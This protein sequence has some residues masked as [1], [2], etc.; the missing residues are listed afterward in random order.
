MNEKRRTKAQHHRSNNNRPPARQASNR[1]AGNR[2]PNEADS[3]Q[4]ASTEQTGPTTCAA[5][6]S[7]LVQNLW[8]GLAHD[9]D[10]AGA[11]AAAVQA[12]SSHKHTGQVVA[13]H[14]DRWL[15]ATKAPYWCTGWG[16]AAWGAVQRNC[17]A[18]GLKR[19]K[20]LKEIAPNPN[21]RRAWS[22]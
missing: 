18:P 11:H 15:L 9:A 13:L 16:K 19:H 5:G 14:H 8:G 3:K 20:V 17:M 6:Q 12:R 10:P 2:S 21:S 1:M 7:N 4:R 22:A